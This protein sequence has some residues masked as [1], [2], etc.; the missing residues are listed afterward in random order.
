MMAVDSLMTAS[1]AL[2][3]E[4]FVTEL[5]SHLGDGLVTVVGSGL[6]CAE[7]LP[8]MAELADHLQATIS[9]S[10]TPD[11]AAQWANLAAII[12]ANRF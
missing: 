12:A 4:T 8:G 7:G 2:D 10:L 1:T 11:D 3:Y 5:Q 6:S 9:G